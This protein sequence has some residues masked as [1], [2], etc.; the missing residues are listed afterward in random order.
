MDSIGFS[1]IKKKLLI[2]I[3]IGNGSISA[4]ENFHSS[5]LL[6]ITLEKQGA[7]IPFV[8]SLAARRSL[9]SL[10]GVYDPGWSFPKVLSCFA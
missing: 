8:F 5:L 1:G 9:R 2:K 10:I 6:E 3:T 4:T 7:E